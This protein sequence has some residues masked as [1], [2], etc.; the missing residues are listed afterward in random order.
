MIG[1]FR[2]CC[3]F[4]FGKSATR[5]GDVRIVGIFFFFTQDISRQLERSFIYITK[6]K[7]PSI[8]PWGRKVNLLFAPLT[9]K[10]TWKRW[11]NRDQ[12]V[13]VHITT[14]VFISL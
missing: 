6:S 10:K 3:L 8:L 11:E 14:I 9:P 13:V 5:D 2:I 7:C 4:E 1:T 12:L